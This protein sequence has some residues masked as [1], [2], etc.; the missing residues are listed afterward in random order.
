[1]STHV[2]FLNL[3][4]FCNIYDSLKE[5]EAEILCEKILS[6]NYFLKKDKLIKSLSLFIFYFLIKK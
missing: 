5:V 4:Y 1:M 6:K 3:L 2:A